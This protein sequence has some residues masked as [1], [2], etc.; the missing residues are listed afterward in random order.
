MTK[1]I[2]Q[3]EEVHVTPRRPASGCRA[4]AACLAAGIG[5]LAGLGA[6][7]ASAAGVS[8]PDPPQVKSVTCL[9]RC[10]DSGKGTV[11]SKVRIVG[12]NFV[13]TISA[14]IGGQQLTKL[15]RAKKKPNVISGL[16]PK[17]AKTAPIKVRNGFGLVGASAKSFGVGTEAELDDALSQ[18]QFPLPPG[19]VTE[20][21][22]GLGAGRGHQGF[23]LMAP[24]G[25]PVYAARSGRVT[26]NTRHSAAGNYLVIKGAGV[27]FDFAYMHLK[28]KSPL[29]V[30]TQ[31]TAGQRIG[32][33]GC[34]GRC[35]G[36]HL[37][38]EMWTR[39]WQQ[40]GK[41]VD[42]EPYLRAWFKA[43]KERKR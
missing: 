1:A 6:D 10:I 9:T 20:W 26:W 3:P 33:V 40:G 11:G 15:A 19:K 34:T 30:G 43:A 7:A 18:W 31:V 22:D 29:K 39:P 35:Y 13:G 27:K 5:A 32:T 42:P 41:P 25:T 12:G 17:G 14:T 38:F 21:G 4:L 37:H 24:S 36:S 23:D 28:R 2:R 16:I 8:P